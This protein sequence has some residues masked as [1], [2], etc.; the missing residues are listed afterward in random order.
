MSGRRRYMM[1]ASLPNKSAVIK[2]EAVKERKNVD[3]EVCTYFVC[4][5][6]I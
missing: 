6:I 3:R 1:N 5:P 4:N 2:V